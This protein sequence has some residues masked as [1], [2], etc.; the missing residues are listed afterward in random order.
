VFAAVILAP[1]RDSD[2]QLRAASRRAGR[3]FMARAVREPLLAVNGWDPSLLSTAPRPDANVADRSAERPPLPEEWLLSAAALG[4]EA[5]QV[6]RLNE[7]LEAGV[8]ELI[9]HGGTSHEF[10]QV[11]TRFIGGE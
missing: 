1:E 9:L 2:E 10:S 8:D 3:Y 6:S 4:S 7:Y 11:V 5:E